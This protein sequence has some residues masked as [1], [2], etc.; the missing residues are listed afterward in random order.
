MLAN[1]K[2]RGEIAKLLREHEAR[3]VIS[4]PGSAAV[5]VLNED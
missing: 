1:G 3:N 5:E 4:E 2:G